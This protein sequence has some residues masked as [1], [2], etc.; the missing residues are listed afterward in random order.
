MR[1]I[2]SIKVFMTILKPLVF[3]V[4]FSYN[5]LFLFAQPVH[6]FLPVCAAQHA[7]TGNNLQLYCSGDNSSF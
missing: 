7:S 2:V 3:Y 6:V 1:N 5:F 4:F